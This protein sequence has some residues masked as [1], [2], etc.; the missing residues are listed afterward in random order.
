MH[1]RCRCTICA[2]IDGVKRKSRIAERRTK[3]DGNV[4]YAEWKAK[5]VLPR[6]LGAGNKISF[7]ADNVPPHILGKI[8]PEFAKATL[9]YFEPYIAETSVENAIIV[10]AKGEVYHCAGDLNGIPMKYFDELGE[11]LNGAEM[12]HNHPIGSDNEYTFSND[13]ISLF[14]R[15]KLARLRGIDEKFVYELNRNAEDIELPISIFDIGDFDG[16]HAQVIEKAMSCDFG[17]R[18][19][20]R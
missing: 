4:T 11:K 19:W 17:Y 12:A 7:S 6:G 20:A 14:E 15:F 3:L 13:D 2:S 16:R 18:R 1:A 9:E 8:T 5:Y 10:T